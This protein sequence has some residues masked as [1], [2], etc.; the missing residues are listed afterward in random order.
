MRKWKRVLVEAV[1]GLL[2]RSADPQRYWERR[3]RK[4]GAHA[5]LNVGHIGEPVQ[6]ISAWQEGI[7]FPLLRERLT[8][9]ERVVLD[10]G[11]G[12]GRF[13]PALAAL[14][15]GRAIGVDHARGLLSLAPRSPEVEYHWVRDSLL[16]IPDDS[17][18]VAWICL[19][20][21]CIPDETTLAVAVSEITR[22]LRPGGLI[23]L[24]DHMAD[25]ASTGDYFKWRPT[26]R[27]ATLFPGALLEQV[28]SYD[29]L[30]ERVTVLAGRVD[31]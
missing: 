31:A 21:S 12:S 19:V 5:V 9:S 6:K 11:C 4:L 29:D 14:V 15:S 24:A 18:D 23:F 25:R 3:A 16:P 1:E 10:F 22:V 26:E 13:T 17:V 28:G 2:G 27:Y 30:G 8:G 20:L 7:L